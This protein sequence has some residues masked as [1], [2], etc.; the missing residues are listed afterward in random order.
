[1]VVPTPIAVTLPEVSTDAIPVAPPLQTPPA[2]V[3]AKVRVRPGH[4]GTEPV[5]VPTTGSALTVTVSD[6]VDVPQLLVMV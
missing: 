6:V 2:V 4:A 3:S 1:M 5:M